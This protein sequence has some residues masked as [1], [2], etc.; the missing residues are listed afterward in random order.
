VLTKKQN[1]VVMGLLHTKE[2][3]GTNAGR[4]PLLKSKFLA[5]FLILLKIV[6]GLNL[7][8][9]ETSFHVLQIRR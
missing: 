7:E 8:C 1:K 2:I 9:K 6:P 3:S 5:V 4:S